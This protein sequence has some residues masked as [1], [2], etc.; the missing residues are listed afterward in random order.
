MTDGL[1][2]VD[3]PSPPPKMEGRN[4]QFTYNTTPRAIPSTPP[5]VSVQANQDPRLGPNGWE[6]LM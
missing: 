2:R 4:G 5:S 1:Q 6:D 3:T